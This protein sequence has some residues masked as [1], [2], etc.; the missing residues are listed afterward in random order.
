MT[1]N[2]AV[3]FLYQYHGNHSKAARAMGR[4]VR[5]YRRLRLHGKGS[6]AAKDLIVLIAE[7]TKREAAM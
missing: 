6:P 1:L 3:D 7:K 5:W 4:D 2:E